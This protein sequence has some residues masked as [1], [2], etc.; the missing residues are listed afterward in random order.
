MTATGSSAALIGRGRELGALIAG[1]DA[2]ADGS[3]QLFLLEGEPGIGK[4]HLARALGD[5]AR[6]R[7][8]DGRVGPLLGGRRRAG[9]LAVDTGVAIRPASA[10][11][12]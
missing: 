7:D 6:A 3:G 9:L 11:P 8:F 12:D 1:L 10:S 5:Q 2:V 4:T